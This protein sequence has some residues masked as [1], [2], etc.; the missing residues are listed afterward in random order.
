M[1]ECEE[2]QKELT[3]SRQ[4]G[5]NR[6]CRLH[7]LHVRVLDTK[8]SL[9]KNKDRKSLCLSLS[10]LPSLPSRLQVPPSTGPISKQLEVIYL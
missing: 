4:H 5:N 9:P 2:M 6:Q 1:R 8:K 3:D 10:Y 7:T